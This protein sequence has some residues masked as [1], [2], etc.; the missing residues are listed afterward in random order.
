MQISSEKQWY[1]QKKNGNSLII[2]WN[3]N[4][5][6]NDF[7][8]ISCSPLKISSK[9]EKTKKTKIKKTRYTVTLINKQSQQNYNMKS[10]H[11]IEYYQWNPWNS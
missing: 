5:H 3:V 1:F 11:K 2:K 9:F 8:D 4:A 7:L 6:M 10:L